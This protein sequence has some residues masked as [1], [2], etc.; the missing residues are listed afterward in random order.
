[1]HRRLDRH[2]RMVHPELRDIGFAGG[3]NLRSSAKLFQVLSLS[4]LIERLQ[5]LLFP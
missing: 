3:S 1:M 2:V 5:F 4:T